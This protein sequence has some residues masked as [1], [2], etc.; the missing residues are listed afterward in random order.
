MNRG[1]YSLP[2]FPC[3]GPQ[4]L[5]LHLSMRDLVGDVIAS[6]SE[7]SVARVSARLLDANADFLGAHWL[8]WC[9]MHLGTKM[10]LRAVGAQTRPAACSWRTVAQPQHPGH[11]YQ[12][13]MTIHATHPSA[14]F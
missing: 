2:P 8:C 5:N 10:L 7:D 9:C 4:M 13:C 14:V 12:S 6:G 3:T 11:P 1:F